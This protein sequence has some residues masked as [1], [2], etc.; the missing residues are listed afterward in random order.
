MVSYPCVYWV[1]RKLEI[2]LGNAG[3]G[4]QQNAISDVFSIWKASRI[5]FMA[6]SHHNFIKVSKYR[7]NCTIDW[8]GICFLVIS[9]H[10]LALVMMALSGELQ[11]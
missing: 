2:A 8:S 11:G 4:I 9:R 5:I 7:W 1:E 6:L 3:K 10:S